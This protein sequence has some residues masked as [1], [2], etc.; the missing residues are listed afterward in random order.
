MRLDVS[1]RAG[2][3]SSSSFIPHKHFGFDEIFMAD[4]FTISA[5]RCRVVNLFWINSGPRK[6]CSECRL[7]S[8]NLA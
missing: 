6:T 4:D 5:R 7:W 1:F 3:R 8:N 2:K